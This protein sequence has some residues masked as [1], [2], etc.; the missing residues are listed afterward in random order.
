MNSMSEQAPERRVRRRRRSGWLWRLI[1]IAAVVVIAL[2]ISM[3]VRAFVVRAFE[4]P[5]D[6]MSPTIAVGD[7][8]AV[9]VLTP[10]WSPYQRGDVV[11][12]RDPGEWIE[13]D[14]QGEQPAL[15]ERIMAALTFWDGSVDA[16][17]FVVKRIIGL[18]GDT[19]D[20]C[21]DYGQ[22]SVNGQAIDERYTLLPA[23]D[24]RASRDAFHVVVPEG[25]VWVLGDNRLV[26]LDSRAH[27]HDERHG[28]VPIADV[29]GRAT[30]VIWPLSQLQWL[31][32]H[33]ASLTGV[34]G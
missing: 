4:V 31:P 34:D 6:S 25:T 19:V 13:S 22:L 10:R 2:L 16:S 5:T 15:L 28:A 14:A 9:D 32:S 20:C 33:R 11:V 18:P 3:L 12:F 7:R 1:D 21:N 17:G 23:G 27:L 26:S 30:A 29:L 24:R 8:I